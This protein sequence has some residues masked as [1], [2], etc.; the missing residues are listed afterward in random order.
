MYL[1]IT[2][3][4][5]VSFPVSFQSQTFMADL[6]ELAKPSEPVGKLSNSTQTTLRRLIYMITKG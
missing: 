4:F 5:L 2:R 3:D 6:I 1:Q